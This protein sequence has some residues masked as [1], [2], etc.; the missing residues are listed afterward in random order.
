[1]WSMINRI[2][3]D[4]VPENFCNVCSDKTNPQKPKNILFRRFDLE[5]LKLIINER[6]KLNCIKPINGPTSKEWLER[7]FPSHQIGIS[8]VFTHVRYF[9][10]GPLV[11]RV[12]M[13]YWRLRRAH[14]T[15]LVPG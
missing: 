10:G 13:V 14:I 8:V 11:A 9:A 12:Y 1:M 3:Q 6:P 15:K 7:F 5:H 4:E 2:D